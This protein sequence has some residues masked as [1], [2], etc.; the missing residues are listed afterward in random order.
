MVGAGWGALAGVLRARFLVPSFIATLG[1]W[2]VLRGLG[3]FG[4]DAL[5]VPL[6]LDDPVMPFLT[7]TIF[8][9]P[10]PASWHLAATRAAPGGRGRGADAR[11]G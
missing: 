11:A 9:V 4:T 5:P 2:S 1:L 7:G 6:P 8:G 3:Q 10:T